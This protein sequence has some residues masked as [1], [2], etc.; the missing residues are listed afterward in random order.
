MMN[1]YDSP[2]K[3]HN[4]G[5][6]VYLIIDL[7]YNLINIIKFYTNKNRLSVIYISLNIFNKSKN[8]L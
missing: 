1:N 2:T 5:R 3:L 7:P 8:Y 6:L 4:G